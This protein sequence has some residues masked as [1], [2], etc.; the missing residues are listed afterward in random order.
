MR[1]AP[2]R[3]TSRQ[4]RPVSDSCGRGLSFAIDWRPAQRLLLYLKSAALVCHL[5]VEEGYPSTGRARLLSV[6]RDGRAV[7]TSGLQ[8][9]QHSSRCDHQGHVTCLVSQHRR[10]LI[11]SSQT[12]ISLIISVCVCVFFSPTSLVPVSLT[13]WSFS[14]VVLSCLAT[15]WQLSLVC[16]YMNVNKGFLRSQNV[17][18]PSVHEE[19]D[20]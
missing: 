12:H 2:V 6:Q 14:T 18:F 1:P 16:H 19:K 15:R 7:D 8:V 5:R 17:E 11:G 13:G 9:P 3:P 10:K 20:T 4:T